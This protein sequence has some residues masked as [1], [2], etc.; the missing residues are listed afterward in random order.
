[1]SLKNTTQKAIAYLSKDAVT[2]IDIWNRFIAGRR[3]LLCERVGVIC[4]N[5]TAGPA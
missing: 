3:K 4:G 1:M 2:Y 5:E